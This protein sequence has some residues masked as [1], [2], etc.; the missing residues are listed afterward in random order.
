MDIRALIAK[1][2]GSAKPQTIELLIAGD[3]IDLTPLILDYM[4]GRDLTPD[5]QQAVLQRIAMGLKE[6][7]PT[8]IGTALTSLVGRYLSAGAPAPPK[9]G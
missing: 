7:A 5:E 8:A 3:R 9:E 1:L 2:F 6:F 4:G